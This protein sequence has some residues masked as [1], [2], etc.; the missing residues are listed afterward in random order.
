MLEKKF[1]KIKII[2]FKKLYFKNTFNFFVNI[3]NQYSIILISGGNSIKRIIQNSKTKIFINKSRTII[4]SDERMYNKIH[5]TRTNY[6]NLKK[7]FFS[8]LN[9]FKLNFIY[10][11]LNLKTE[12]LLKNFIYKI[13]KKIPK[14]ALLSLGNDGHICS[15]FKYEKQL[16]EYKYLNIVKPKYKIKR[17][18]LNLKFLKK[19]KKIY[20]IVNGSKK[21][22]AL[23]KII[24]KKKT[25]FPLKN[26]DK[27]IFVLDKNA[28]QKIKY[29]KNVE[30]INFSLKDK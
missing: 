25:I 19:I 11:R 26:F 30:Q 18:T 2:Y 28:Y 4:L 10:Y 27:I 3:L 17:I 13:K 22:L 23:R 8:Y 9:F 7:N 5:D 29:I 12:A 24:L 6:S 21:G 14:V 16:I 20:L 1:M 15:I